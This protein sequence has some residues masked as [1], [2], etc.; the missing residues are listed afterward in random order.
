MPLLTELWL[1]ACSMQ[2]DSLK[3]HCRNT[4]LTP[5]SLNLHMEALR[6]LRL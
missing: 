4:D 1:P 6:Q 3:H 5:V 2:L